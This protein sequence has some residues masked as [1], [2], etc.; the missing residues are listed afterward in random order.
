MHQ[1][2]VRTRVLGVAWRED[3][4]NLQLAQGTMCLQ[5]VSPGGNGQRT[6][7]RPVRP[8]M[9]PWRTWAAVRPDA[10]QGSRLPKCTAASSWPHRT[11]ARSSDTEPS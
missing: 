7:I 4:R 1:S 11:R 5:E 10:K 3:A 9:T 6:R 2:E 8:A